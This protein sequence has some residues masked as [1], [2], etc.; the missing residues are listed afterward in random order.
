MRCKQCTHG[1]LENHLTAPGWL[2]SRGVAIMRDGGVWSLSDDALLAEGLLKCGQNPAA[3]AEDQLPGYTSSQIALRVQ[4]RTHRQRPA[5][6][7]K[8]QS[9]L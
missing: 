3:I 1:Q 4:E 9:R 2:L 7:V 8:V 5:N 6:V